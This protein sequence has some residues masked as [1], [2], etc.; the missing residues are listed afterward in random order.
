MFDFVKRLYGEGKIRAEV[1]FAD[2]SFAV[3]KVPYI[4]DIDTLDL[5]EFRADI[6]RKCL[7][8]HGKYVTSVKIIGWY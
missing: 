2:G 1:D 8:D 3:V 5:G 7:V 4:G 6:R